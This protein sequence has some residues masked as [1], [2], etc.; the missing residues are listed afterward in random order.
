MGFK[1]RYGFEGWGPG[2]SVPDIY[3][4]N[5][6]YS[7]NLVSLAHSTRSNAQQIKPSSTHTIKRVDFYGY[8]TDDPIVSADS[9]IKIYAADANHKPTGSI[10]AQALFDF[11]LLPLAAN[12]GWN[13]IPLDAFTELTAE[14]EYCIVMESAAILGYSDPIWRMDTAAGYT[15]G[16]SLISF[17]AGAT[18]TAYSQYDFVFR[19]WGG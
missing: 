2:F 13:T 11:S 14:T 7:G 18:W 4:A 19:E 5:E 9:Y 10:L 8:R 17:D 15:R 6:T 3:E 12:E 1:T 16:I